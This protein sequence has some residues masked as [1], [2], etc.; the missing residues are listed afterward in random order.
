MELLPKDRQWELYP[1]HT[2]LNRHERKFLCLQ[3]QPLKSV[4]SDSGGYVK[5]KINLIQEI[6]WKLP[7]TVN[8]I[9]K[10]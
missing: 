3:R 1:S 8:K 9:R 2:S 6:S 10:S 5:L 7:L 4:S